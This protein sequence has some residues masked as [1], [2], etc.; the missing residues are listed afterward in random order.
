M[1]AQVETDERKGTTP[2]IT[3][4]AEWCKAC[5]FCV[6]FCPTDVLR[7]ERTLPV[8]VDARRC[9]R[10]QLCVA[11]CPDFAIAVV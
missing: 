5:E 9:S 1:S 6:M 2:E 7:M 4:R 3:I 11:V 10:C 8:V